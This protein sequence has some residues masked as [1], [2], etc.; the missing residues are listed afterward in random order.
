[1]GTIKT[2]WVSVKGKRADSVPSVA[3]VEDALVA[4]KSKSHG[5]PFHGTNEKTNRL[6]NWN[7]E[8]L[9]HFLKETVAKRSSAAKAVL[10][11]KEGKMAALSTDLR[12]ADTPLEEVREIVTLLEIDTGKSHNEVDPEKAEMSPVVTEQLH[13]LVSS[14]AGMHSINPF[15]M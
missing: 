3:T 15:H 11:T 2:H 5:A 8:I 13:H 12:F 1:M 4:L 10:K 7:V 9:L 6:V 14:V